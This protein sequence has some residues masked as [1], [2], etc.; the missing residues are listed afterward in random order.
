V[1]A[2]STPGNLIVISGPS[3]A[4]KTTVA[5]RLLQDP[6]FERARTATTRPPRGDE[7]DGIDYDFLSVDAFRK[8]LAND[9]FLEHAEVYGHLYGTPRKNLDAVRA[10]GRHA[11]LVVDVQGVRTL[12]ETGVDAHYVFVTAPDDTELRRRLESRGEDDEE[13]IERRLAQ[14]ERE[15]RAT[16][17]FDSVVVNDDVDA[18][19][20]RLIAQAGLEWAP[21]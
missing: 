10:K 12:R 16:D 15:A 11:V 6:R 2:A 21:R 19:V 9:A 5:R 17:L 8:G 13:T 4:G 20:G 3:G 1:S 7:Q 18:A 14:A